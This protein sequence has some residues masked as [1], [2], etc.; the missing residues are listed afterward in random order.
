ML[1]WEVPLLRGLLGTYRVR[2]EG[3]GATASTTFV[4]S[5]A[6]TPAYRILGSSGVT[7]RFLVVGLRA[8][9]A[10]TFRAYDGSHAGPGH[11]VAT[12]RG[13]SM[14]MHADERGRLLAA[15][16]ARSAPRS[17]CYVVKAEVQGRFLYDADNTLSTFCRG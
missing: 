13:S 1:M 14:P 15:F 12:Y 9:E 4:L 5:A 16:D 8:G 2:A 17:A 10:V 3:A 6:R 11:L 7:A